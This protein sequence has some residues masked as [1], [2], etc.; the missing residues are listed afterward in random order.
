MELKAIVIV[1]AIAVVFVV[2]GHINKR[3]KD[4]RMA[5]H[6]RTRRRKK[7]KKTEQRWRKQCKWNIIFEDCKKD[8]GKWNDFFFVI[9][10][11]GYNHKTWNGIMKATIHRLLFQS[12][13]DCKC[14]CSSLLF[15]G[16]LLLFDMQVTDACE[17]WARHI[18]WLLNVLIFIKAIVFV[19]RNIEIC[20]RQT[21]YFDALLSLSTHTKCCLK[22]QDFRDKHSYWFIQKKLNMNLVVSLI[23]DKFLSQ[24]LNQWWICLHSP[25]HGL[26]KTANQ[27][28]F[29]N[30]CL[31][32]RNK[33]Y[34]EN[35]TRY[36]R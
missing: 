25:Q 16:S 5:K 1:A 13:Y 18:Y 19:L 2:V 17:M 8:F 35:K 31:R 12:L 27:L 14:F 30:K 26:V 24:N 33:F 10:G 4:E 29:R 15:L 7:Q 36:R 9:L 21:F 6:N 22:I 20:Q 3:M 32:P 34:Q 23:V 11:V 28:L